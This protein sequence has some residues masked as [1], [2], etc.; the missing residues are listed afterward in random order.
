MWAISLPYLVRQQ[1]RSCKNSSVSVEKASQSLLHSQQI[2]S[3]LFSAGACTWQKIHLRLQV[4]NLFAYGEQIMRA[5]DCKNWRKSPKGFFDKLNGAVKTAPFGLSIFPGCQVLADHQRHSED[6][7]VI[8]FPQ[9][10][11]GE[12]LDLFQTVNQGVTVDEQLPGGFGYVQ[13]VL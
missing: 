2:K 10:Q 7:G 6:N 1:K 12:L 4:W 5:A 8:E 3:K 13:I 11:A 9:I